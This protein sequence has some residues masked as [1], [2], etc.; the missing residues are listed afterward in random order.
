MEEVKFRVKSH[1]VNCFEEP[2][3]DLPILGGLKFKQISSDANGLLL[4]PFTKEEIKGE[5][6]WNC[7]G[8]KS[9]GSNEFN[10][11]FIKE[12]WGLL[13]GDIVAFLN[14]FYFYL[15][16]NDTFAMCN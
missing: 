1:F 13:H 16:S 6:M 5:E 7:D 14:K 15:Y 8:D 10:L 11:K 4:L 12:S 3:Q 2:L 9:L